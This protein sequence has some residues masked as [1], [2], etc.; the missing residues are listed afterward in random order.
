MRHPAWPL[1]LFGLATL[2]SGSP[3][4]V[5]AQTEVFV[6]GAA[7]LP[8]GDFGE[9]AD[10]GIHGQLG[11]TVEVGTSGF[12]VAA[13]GFFGSLPHAIAGDRSDLYGAT[14]LT[15]YT[16][17][18]AYELRLRTWAGVGG[19]VHTRKSD[20]FPGLDGSKRGL[21][22]SGGAV[23]SRPVGRISLFGS[24]FYTR[25]L[26]DLGTSS[27]PTEF[28]TIGGGVSIPLSRD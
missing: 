24:G 13:S 3:D 22:V 4:A 6:A 14:V 19:M 25:G 21:S 1:V 27:Y 16:I 10:L 7:A 5:A 15:G 12:A 28:V 17:V 20:R 11:G 23:V 9:I 18:D 26:G 2:G 8:L